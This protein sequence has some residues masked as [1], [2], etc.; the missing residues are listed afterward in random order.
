MTSHY[1][2]LARHALLTG[3]QCAGLKIGAKVGMPRLICSEVEK[4]LRAADFQIV[5]YHV[6]EGL[7]PIQLSTVVEM[8]EAIIAVNYFGFPANLDYFREIIGNRAI[9]LIED[10]AH[11]WLSRDSRGLELGHRADVG[12]T[13]FRKTIRSVDGAILTLS[14]HLDVP[15]MA[16]L[17][18]SIF[19][20]NPGYRARDWISQVESKTHMPMMNLARSVTRSIRRASVKPSHGVSMDGIERPRRPHPSSMVRLE[21]TNQRREIERRRDRW[22]YCLQESAGTGITPVHFDLPSGV[23]PMG[24]AFYGSKEAARKYSRRIYRSGIEVFSWPEM[25]C[26]SDSVTD[27]DYYHQLWI[28]NFLQ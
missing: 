21:K 28:A 23:C 18:P 10:N 24:F 12:I 20:I 6:S 5:Y 8:C 9:V 14:S 16:E 15:N 19:Q 1:F 22:L 17:G 27:L 25:S 26:P 4:S 7:H 2:S 3:L 11:G 13:S